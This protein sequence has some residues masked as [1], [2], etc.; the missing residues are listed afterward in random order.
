MLKSEEISWQLKKVKYQPY[1]DRVQKFLN[2]RNLQ[3]IY[4]LFEIKS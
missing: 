3:K 2:R 1:T 4:S